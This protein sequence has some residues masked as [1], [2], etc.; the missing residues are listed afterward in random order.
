MSRGIACLLAETDEEAQ[1]LARQL[2]ELNVER[3]K[4]EGEM[5]VQA[6]EA[7]DKLAVLSKRGE[8]DLPVALCLMD[9]AWH[10]GVIGI[11]AGRLKERY[12]RPVITF[13]K[14]SADEI[15]G[16][17]RSIPNVNIR[18]VLASVDRANPGVITK[19]GGHAMAAGLS[20]S[21][22][23]FDV[24]KQCFITEMEKELAGIALEG[25]V[26]SDGSLDA[27]VF[28]LAFAKELQQGGP[29]GQQ[30][31]EPI[32]DDAFE[33]LDQRLVGKNHLKLQLMHEDGGE[34]ID[35]IAF[36]IDLATWPNKRARRVHA[37][38]KLDINV[39]RNRERLQLLISSLSVL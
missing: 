1:T 3:R 2:D 4:I 19:F 16:S 15:K 23:N 31:P 5:Q 7:L 12:H 13:A 28:N 20:L 22:S 35:A 27:G 24:F 32:F 21:P 10:Q 8:G 6:L 17:A 30:F 36:N 18:D 26:L 29:W 34:A 9:E 38:Y 11:L 39:F 25:S 14:V 37:A 33:V